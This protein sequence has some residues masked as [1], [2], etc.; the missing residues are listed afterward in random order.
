MDGRGKDERN[1]IRL[2]CDALI[3]YTYNIA[4]TF[5]VLPFFASKQ[6]ITYTKKKKNSKTQRIQQKFRSFEN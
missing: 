4:I 1:K 2:C 3:L 5:I 6:N